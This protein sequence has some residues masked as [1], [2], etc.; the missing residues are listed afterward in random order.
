[1]SKCSHWPPPKREKRF[2]LALPASILSVEK[3]LLSKTLKIGFIA[4]TLSIFRIDKAIVYRDSKATMRDYRVLRIILEYLSTPPHLRKKLFPL[5]PELRYVGLLPPIQ[6]PSHIVPEEPAPGI[7]IDGL[8]EKCEGDSCRVYLGSKMGYGILGKRVRPGKLITVEVL[9]VEEGVIRLR[10][11]KPSFYWRYRVETY[12]SLK[13]VIGKYSDKMIIVGTS[14]LG[15]C[16]KDIIRRTLKGRDIL[17]VFGGPEGHVW[18]E[19][20]KDG[21]DLIINS[22]PFQGTRTIRTEEAVMLSIKY[23]DDLLE[24]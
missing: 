21:F 15:T 18:D 3:S 20:D 23:I 10:Q 5:L 1:M 12:P 19:L 6:A 11:V 17:I 22:I 24:S 4:R 8:V 16:D 2:F 13:Q 14:R 7:I 9:K